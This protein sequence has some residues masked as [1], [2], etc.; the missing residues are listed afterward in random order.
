VITGFNP[1]HGLPGTR[2]TIDGTNF[3]GSITVTFNGLEASSFTVTNNGRIGATVPAGAETGPIA[4]TGPAGTGE[5]ATDFVVEFSSD[6][7]VLVTDAPDPVFV[8]SNLVYSIITS[9][10]GPHEA[11]NVQLTNTLPASVTLIAASTAQGTL[12]TNSNPVIATIGTIPAGSSRLVTLT[13]QP[14]AAGTITNHATAGSSNS[15]A[16]PD[17]N[18]S[19]QT[20]LIW[21]LPSLSIRLLTNQVEL[22][23][24]GALSHF[25]V[26]FT[27]NI[28]SGPWITINEPP[29]VTNDFSFLTY[30]N[31]ATN[32]FFRLKE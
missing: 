32:G 16:S 19:S 8:G 22:S 7:S 26:Q 17:N 20:T 3:L 11:A 12:A 2:V 25:G 13:V 14:Q 9:N 4:I 28:G 1:T 21:P 24:P 6:M 30:S 10:S 29:V 31:L 18:S 5:S 23:W 27:T 15:D